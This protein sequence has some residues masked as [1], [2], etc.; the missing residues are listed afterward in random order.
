MKTE[1]K[2][3]PKSIWLNFGEISEDEAQD[4][5]IRNF[6]NITWYAGGDYN[7][8][9]DEGNYQID[10]YDVK[11]IRKS[12]VEELIDEM[13]DQTKQTISDGR[14]TQQ[15]LGSSNMLIIKLIELKDKL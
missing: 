7:K 11:Y 1:C 8:I 4:T 14:L 13:I 2:A 3:A 10:D 6:D 5:D 12:F 9:F 15:A